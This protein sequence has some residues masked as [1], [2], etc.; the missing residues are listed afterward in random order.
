MRIR[1]MIPV[2]AVA[3][4]VAAAPV[5]QAAKPIALVGKVGLKDS[6][7]ISLTRLGKPVKTLKPGRYTITVHDYSSIHNF[8]LRGPGVNKATSVPA[9]QTVTWTVTL[10]KGAYS[11]VCDPHQV[12]MKQTFVVKS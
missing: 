1:V 8:R 4:L 2:L 5:A 3:A 7:T 11:V 10:K 12:T 6:F 9:V